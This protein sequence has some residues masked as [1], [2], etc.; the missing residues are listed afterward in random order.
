MSVFPW[1][2]I[3]Q[4]LFKS[5]EQEDVSES[6]GALRVLYLVA[7]A[8]DPARPRSGVTFAGI[9]PPPCSLTEGLMA[10]DSGSHSHGCGGVGCSSHFRAVMELAVK[11]TRLFSEQ[12]G[13]VH[14]KRMLRSGKH[15]I[16]STVL[17]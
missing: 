16:F 12:Q 9:L 3:P 17:S 15:P 1:K 14:W 7:A 10:R 6:P 2:Y 8:S 11:I 13:R 4:E 5:A